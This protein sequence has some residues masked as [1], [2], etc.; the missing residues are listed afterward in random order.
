M[1]G[2]SRRLPNERAI[3][4]GLGVVLDEVASCLGV[5]QPAGQ[6]SRAPQMAEITQERGSARPERCNPL[7]F[8]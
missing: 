3:R 6:P 5:L 2:A 1:L 8:A 7:H 4:S